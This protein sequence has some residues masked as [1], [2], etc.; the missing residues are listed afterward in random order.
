MGI[1][2]LRELNSNKKGGSTAVREGFD[3]LLGLALKFSDTTAGEEGVQLLEELKRTFK[4]NSPATWKPNLAKYKEQVSVAFQVKMKKQCSRR[5]S[6]RQEKTRVYT[7][8][9]K[10]TSKGLTKTNLCTSSSGKVVSVKAHEHGVE[11]YKRNLKPFQDSVQAARRELELKG[12]VCV[13]G[14]TPEGTMLKQRAREIHAQ[15]KSS[16]GGP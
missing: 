14:K 1:D 13:G 8:V 15:R 16:S 3:E 6:R 4:S 12:F 2:R 10:R 5:A 7:G 9:A 11:M